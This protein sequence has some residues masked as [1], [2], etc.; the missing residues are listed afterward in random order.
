MSITFTDTLTIDGHVFD[1]QPRVWDDTTVWV[2]DDCHGADYLLAEVNGWWAWA[3]KVSPEVTLR[4]EPGRGQTRNAFS[5]FE[6]AQ[7]Q[8]REWQ[9]LNAW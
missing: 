2:H 7:V 1:A 3:A 5:A 4:A 8:V 6:A 9:A